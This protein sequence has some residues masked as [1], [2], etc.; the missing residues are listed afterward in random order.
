ML[1]SFHVKAATAELADLGSLYTQSF[2]SG[3]E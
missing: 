1:P 3:F 2:F